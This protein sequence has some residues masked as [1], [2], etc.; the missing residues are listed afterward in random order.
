MAYKSFL[1]LNAV[2]FFLLSCCV[3][4]LKNILI[5]FGF[6]TET[7]AG[8]TMMHKQLPL[9]VEEKRRWSQFFFF[10]IIIFHNSR[11]I[12]LHILQIKFLFME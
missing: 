3:Q 9:Q 7:Y 10:F 6:T 2:F 11:V 5:L 8:M 1:T 12:V 4:I